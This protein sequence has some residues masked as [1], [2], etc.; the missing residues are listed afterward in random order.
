MC[1]GIVSETP[2]VLLNWLLVREVPTSG[3]VLM[4]WKLRFCLVFVSAM[5][6]F[7][8]NLLSLRT[9]TMQVQD[10]AEAYIALY[11]FLSYFHARPTPGTPAPWS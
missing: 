11:I 7:H 5:C 1:A 8:A 3:Q 9:L 2:R 6:L 10:I 4:V